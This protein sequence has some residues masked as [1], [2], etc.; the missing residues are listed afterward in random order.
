MQDTNNHWRKGKESLYI[1]K[2]TKLQ[3]MWRNPI[4]SDWSH[5]KART[6]EELD[7]DI[8]KT[9]GQIRHEQGVRILKGA[10]LLVVLILIIRF[11]V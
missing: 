11:L 7:K 1:Q 8:K 4:D 9:I 3:R 10:F 6:D 5:V 2:M